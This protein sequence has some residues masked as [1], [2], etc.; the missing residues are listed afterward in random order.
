M[1]KTAH[2]IQTSI[3]LIIIS[4]LVILT[5]CINE[6]TIEKS[7]SPI[8]Y[9]DFIELTGSTQQV[10]IS[11]VSLQTVAWKYLDDENP[12]TGMN[13]ETKQGFHPTMPY[14]KDLYYYLRGKA[15]LA[16]G[17]RLDNIIITA[18]F[19]NINNTA[20]AIDVS[21]SIA[22]LT[23]SYSSFFEIRLYKKDTAF[24]DDISYITLDIS[25]ND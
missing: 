9:N 23:P 3:I 24:F 20:I 17:E 7:S 14:D 6:K 13:S 8:Q 10:N 22:V 2:L 15:S 12:E 1:K 25:V 5:G 4:F 19:T 18:T 11:Q 21:D 16:Q